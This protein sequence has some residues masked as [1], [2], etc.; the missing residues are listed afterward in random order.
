M[1]P[2]RFGIVTTAAEPPGGCRR[3]TG[4]LNT[5]S[6]NRR[7]ATGLAHTIR[8]AAGLAI[9]GVMLAGGM[10]LAGCSGSSA[11]SAGSASG[12]AAPPAAAAAPGI[13]APAAGAAQQRL[14]AAGQRGNHG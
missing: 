6:L 9:G 13:G 10:L 3:H 7:S 11:S 2:D 8:R 4:M 5:L 14:G 12:V 1:R